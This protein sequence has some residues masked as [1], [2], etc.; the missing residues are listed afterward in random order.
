M[1]DAGSENEII[2]GDI[3]APG[4]RRAKFNLGSFKNR[5]PGIYYSIVG[6]LSGI[7]FS[8]GVRHGSD[9]DVQESEL[10]GD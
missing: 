5:R 9:G 3:I 1:L 2:L 7:L 4:H 10:G 8:A 6:L